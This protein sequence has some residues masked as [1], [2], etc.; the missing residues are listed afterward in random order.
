MHLLHY[1]TCR[2][3]VYTWHHQQ[4]L[5]LEPLVCRPHLPLLVH[6]NSELLL[7]SV[8]KIYIIIM[9][10]CN[11]T[12]YCKFIHLGKPCTC[13]VQLTK[14]IEFH[15]WILMTNPSV[16]NLPLHQMTYAAI[17][18]KI[19]ISIKLSSQSFINNII[20]IASG[21]THLFCVLTAS[22]RSLLKS[23]DSVSKSFKSGFNIF[24]ITI[25][26]SQY[27]WSSSIQF[28]SYLTDL[29]PLFVYQHPYIIFNSNNM[30]LMYMY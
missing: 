2:T 17:F 3:N 26:P 22:K 1:T 27:S 5:V 23:S 8:W 28:N 9:R 4:Y 14:K 13:I 30:L 19:H 25:V 16:I 24:M 11:I 18:V 20:L 21:S 7:P 6:L 12:S 29:L 10:W 15:F